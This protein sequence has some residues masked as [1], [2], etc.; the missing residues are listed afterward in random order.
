GRYPGAKKKPDAQPPERGSL[1]VTGIDLAR[2]AP[3]LHFSALA[4]LRGRLDVVFDFDDDLSDG[5][6]RVIVRGLRWGNEAVS[7][8]L[9]GLLRF[10][11]G[12]LELTDVGGSIAGGVLRA[13]GRVRLADPT[14]NYF[15]LTIN[16]A[17]SARLLA[18]VPGLAKTVTGPLTLVVR[19]HL[20]RETR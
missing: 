6:G 11:D 2:L 20:G 10:R 19:G 9:I 15:S 7:Q 14:Q 12:L 17:D 16:G 3:D 13:R 5:S 8:E 4:P 18:P 1:R